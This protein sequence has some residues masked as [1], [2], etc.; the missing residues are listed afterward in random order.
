MFELNNN[1]NYKNK[2]LKINLYAAFTNY[3]CTHSFLLHQTT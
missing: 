2:Q 3:Y 1:M